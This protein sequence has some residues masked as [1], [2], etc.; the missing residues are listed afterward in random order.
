[1]YLGSVVVVVP[2]VVVVVFAAA[3]EL[4]M[5]SANNELEEKLSVSPAMTQRTTKP[6]RCQEES[7]VFAKA[8]VN[9]EEGVG[10]VAFVVVVVVVVG[11]D[12]GNDNK[13]AT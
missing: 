9:G 5:Y 13:G 6:H 11:G 1:V 4:F 3:G 8:Q 10:V 7:T 2:V 12:S